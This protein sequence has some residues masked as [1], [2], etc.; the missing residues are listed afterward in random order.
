M[1]RYRVL[2]LMYLLFT[3]LN[4]PMQALAAPI[5]VLDHRNSY[6]PPVL[7]QKSGPTEKL[8]SLSDPHPVQLQLPKLATDK[9]YKTLSAVPHVHRI[10]LPG[11]RSVMI[12][13][14]PKGASYYMTLKRLSET[15][16]NEGSWPGKDEFY[17]AIRG[18]VKA[19]VNGDRSV[20]EEAT[21]HNRETYVRLR[22]L[23]EYL[24]FQHIIS[25]RIST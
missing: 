23:R 8:R 14:S 7:A 21:G 2:C 12:A 6:I 9:T 4:R 10:P 3:F 1:L 15:L 24:L 16:R 25:L 11:T 20:L 22:S 18:L 19:H 17:T 13:R 5:S